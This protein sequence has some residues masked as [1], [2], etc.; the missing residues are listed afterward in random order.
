MKVLYVNPMS[1]N[2]L[3]EYDLNLLKEMSDLGLQV[4]YACNELIFEEQEWTHFATFSVYPIFRYRKEWFF[5]RKGFSYFTSIF[6]ILYLTVRNRPDLVHYQ[7][8]KLPVLDILLI[9]LLKILKIPVVYTSH[10]FL[11][12]KKT[13]LSFFLPK[14]FAR[15]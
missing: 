8:A 6:T 11:P 10:N 7:W 5:F 15:L 13:A 12:H 9:R 4:E 14:L 2:N 3:G 1:Y